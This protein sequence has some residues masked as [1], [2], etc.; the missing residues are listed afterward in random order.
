LGLICNNVSTSE[1]AGFDVNFYSPVL[2]KLIG[3]GLTE[4]EKIEGWQLLFDG[5][6]LDG[7][8]DFNGDS[9]T[10]PWHVVDGCIQAKGDGS[11]LSGYIVTEKQFE[12]FIVDRWYPSS[13]ICHYCGNIKK[14][15]KLSDRI[16]RCDCG[17]VEDRDFNASLN[18]R[19]AKTYEIA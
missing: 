19:D 7:W 8:K 13:K 4:A 5:K 6:T 9:L 1:N 2:Y 12:N 10:Q 18:L 16:Y 3:E 15:L 17:Y 14:D 11:D